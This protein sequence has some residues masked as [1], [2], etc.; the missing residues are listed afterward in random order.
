M[1]KQEIID[2]LEKNH[3]EL[4]LW[5]D[6]NGFKQWTYAPKGKWTTGQ[7]IKHLVRSLELLNQAL[8]IPKFILK[9]KFGLSNRPVRDYEHVIIRYQERLLQ[10]KGLDLPVSRNMPIPESKEYKL[11]LKKLEKHKLALIKKISSWTEKEL[12]SYILPHPLMGKM[13][14]KEISM[15]TAYH[16]QHHT[17]QLIENYTLL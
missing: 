5:L 4:F 13:P 6:S 14:V 7:Q 3:K 10:S 9:W 2:L 12:E 1:T 11:L 8:K 17:Q 15:W 16:T